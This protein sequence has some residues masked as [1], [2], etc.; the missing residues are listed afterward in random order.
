MS[1]VKA[2][3]QSC[4]VFFYNVGQRVGVD[5]LAWYAKECGLGSRTGVK[6]DHEMQGLIPTAAWKKRRFGIEWQEGETLSLAIGQ[7]F[8]LVTPLQM[9][10]LISAVA[11]GG[12]R[13]RP[14]IFKRIETAEGKIIRE[15][16]PQ[17][18]GRLPVSSK[19]MELVK[20]G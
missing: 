4:H 5:R 19:T 8:N 2:L 10:T 6:L 15:T 9:L 17:K 14:E 16:K 3:A 13:Y 12:T 18:I 7:G 1:I 20:Q 11:N